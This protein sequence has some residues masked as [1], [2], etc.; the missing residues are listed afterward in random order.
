M[1]PELLKLNLEKYIDNEQIMHR[2]TITGCDMLNRRNV[3][4]IT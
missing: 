1:I 3:K 2:L 4:N